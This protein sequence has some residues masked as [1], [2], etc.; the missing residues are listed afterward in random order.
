MTGYR[1]KAAAL[2]LLTAIFTASADAYYLPESG[3]TAC[4]DD[5]GTLISCPATGDS[6][7]QDG[8]YS[9]NP[10]SFK[11]NSNTVLD[12]NTGLMWQKLDD[13]ITRTWDGANTYCGGLVLDGYSDW[14]L[15]SKGELVSIVDYAIFYPGPA[16]NTTFFPGTA[17]SYYWTA[18]PYANDA[19]S[20]WMVYFYTGSNY[21]DLKT[22]LYN[23]RCVRGNRPSQS[24]VDN[25]DGTV[26]D[27]ITGLMWQ[28][29]EGALGPWSNSIFYCENQTLGRYS[30]WRVPNIKELES[31]TADTEYQPAIDISF[32]PSAVAGYYWSS[33]T[34]NDD[35]PN[36]AWG[37]DFWEGRV[38]GS[39]K[40]VF[41]NVNL[42]C[43]RGGNVP[44]SVTSPAQFT[45]K[46]VSS[47]KIM[48]G[49]KDR[50][51]NESGFLI[52]RKPGNCAS[53]G[54]WIRIAA[55][56]A[57]T[58]QFAD[59]GLSADTAYSYRVRAYAASVNSAYTACVTAT[60]A[61]S[62]TPASPLNLKAYASAANTVDLS[63]TDSSAV[64]TGF[65]IWK[66]KDAGAWTKITTT[67]SNVR[68]YKD[69]DAAG[70]PAISKYQYA[71]KACNA[72]GCSPFT[73]T[74]AVP[75]KPTTLSAT[76]LSSTQV[77]LDWV[78]PA[79]AITGFK[80][81]RKE[82]SCSSVNAWLMVGTISSA[83]SSYSDMTA[84][85]AKTYS[86]RIRSYQQSVSVPTAEGNSLFS[87][88]VT[89]TTP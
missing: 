61:N 43:V 6:L 82:G 57:D 41:T 56:I 24:L 74:A 17:A 55:D 87:N 23:V 42:R 10:M 13:G 67:A 22:A 58:V 7:A 63:W 44:V 25:K 28:Q 4:Y 14:R 75:Y 2:M 39:S 62:G 68:A 32:F 19:N 84:A 18:T 20:A 9:I 52:E 8:S 81:Q 34:S 83:G 38:R 37:V 54:S 50:A 51:A 86:Y 11:G 89:V 36:S 79:M 73:S 1:I 64:E 3:Q 5:I 45:A 16:I 77:N 60:T 30:D 76:A 71:L 70:N 21:F 46:A 59:S 35:N 12:D 33:T 48:L 88:C 29:G 31:L 65:E 85:S 27:S 78:K 80:L 66:K 15:P 49:W 69:T 47:S 26:S 72:K 40:K 53:A